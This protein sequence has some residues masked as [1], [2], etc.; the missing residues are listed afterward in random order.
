LAGAAFLAATV[1]DAD[2][3]F[4]GA[5]LLAGVIVSSFPTTYAVGSLPRG[6]G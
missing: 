4:A 6:S 3:F 5:A 2:A 1:R